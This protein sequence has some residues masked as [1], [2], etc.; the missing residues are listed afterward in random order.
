MA[1]QDFYKILGVEKSASLT[2]IKK[3]YRNLVNIY[4]PDKNTKKS[5]EEQKQAEAKFKEIQEAY[6]ILSDETK[7]KQYDKFGHAAFDQ[8]FGGGLVAFQDLIL[9]IFFQVLPLVLV[10]AAHKNKN[11]VVL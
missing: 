6:E 7:R 11:I 3:A 9:A 8:Q 10:L 4:H 1:K 2:E 5:A